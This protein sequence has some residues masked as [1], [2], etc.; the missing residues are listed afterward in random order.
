MFFFSEWIG[1][2]GG[3]EILYPSLH[4]VWLKIIVTSS[5]KS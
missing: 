5:Y 3:I 1:Q 2:G 4:Y